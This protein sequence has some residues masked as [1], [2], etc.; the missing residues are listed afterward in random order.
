MV[1]WPSENTGLALEECEKHNL[2][3]QRN[4]QRMYFSHRIILAAFLICRALNTKLV[5]TS[6]YLLS[7]ELMQDERLKI[8]I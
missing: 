3:R 2:P 8:L 1:S 5:F 4:K 7:S 6:R